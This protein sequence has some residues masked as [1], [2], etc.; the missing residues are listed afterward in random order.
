[1]ITK[2]DAAKKATGHFWPLVLPSGSTVLFAASLGPSADSD[3]TI[4]SLESEDQRVLAQGSYP[5]VG[6]GGDLIFARTFSLWA[7][8]LTS[9]N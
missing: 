5:R 8:E 3:L 7:A 6:P 9:P 4:K 1:M 2:I